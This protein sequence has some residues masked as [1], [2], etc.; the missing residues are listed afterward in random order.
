M[1]YYIFRAVD[2][3]GLI[4]IVGGYV[5]LFLGYSILQFPD[6]I[7]QLFFK[8]EKYRKRN[9]NNREKVAPN[10]KDEN[11]ERN[12]PNQEFAMECVVTHQDDINDLHSVKIQLNQLIQ[13]IKQ[14]EDS[15]HCMN[16]K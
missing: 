3:N 9:L 14:I 8:L 16:N 12:E 2:V 6:S 7:L 15:T 13:K 1:I 5:G 11:V 10:S 4:G